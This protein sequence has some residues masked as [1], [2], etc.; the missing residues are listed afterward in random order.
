MHAVPFV[1]IV[2]P[3][4]LIFT[5]LP[6][7]YR[8]CHYAHHLARP[9]D[10]NIIGI[11]IHELLESNVD[12]EYKLGEIVGEESETNSEYDDSK[13]KGSAAVIESCCLSAMDNPTVSR[14]VSS[15][16]GGDSTIPDDSVENEVPESLIPNSNPNS[17]S[18]SNSNTVESNTNDNRV[19]E[20]ESESDSSRDKQMNEE[21]EAAVRKEK[22]ESSGMFRFI[23]DGS[24]G[25]GELEAGEVTGWR[26]TSVRSSRCLCD[27]DKEDNSK[28]MCVLS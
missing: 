20:S 22:F 12:E 7:D 18:I 6:F 23:Y 26:K 27:K 10:G 2:I 4:L 9:Q 15:L 1:P 25:A 14:G 8:H 5:L 17:N 28:G 13:E 16:S 21:A 3:R 19:S 24:E 11:W